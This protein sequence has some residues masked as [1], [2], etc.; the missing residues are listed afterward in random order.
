MSGSSRSIGRTVLGIGVVLSVAAVGF[1]DGG[2]LLA[3]SADGA[4]DG[5]G[6]LRHE[7]VEKT[8]EIEGATV[9]E[10]ELVP[11][12][13]EEL[14]PGYI[15]SHFSQKLNRR[16]WSFYRA[17]AGFWDALGSGTIQEARLLDFRAPEE[18][19]VE[20]IRQVAPGLAYA[21][22]R[23]RQRA[24]ARLTEDNEWELAKVSTHPTVYSLNTGRR[25]DWAFGRY[26][27]VRHTHGDR[28]AFREGKYVPAGR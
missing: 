22:V 27:P 15:Y 8:S 13:P 28:W 9:Q 26:I 4:D 16:V 19:Q 14:K 18:K 10:I 1:F 3:E 7:L 17:D 2:L 21:I 11:V 5:R 20:A 23:G 25:W 24:F 12:A 6:I